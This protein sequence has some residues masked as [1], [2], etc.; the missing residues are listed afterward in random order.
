M[1]PDLKFCPI[2]DLVHQ[3]C[4]QKL[5]FLG[6]VDLGFLDLNNILEWTVLLMVMWSWPII[7]QL[8]DI[9]FCL[10][11]YISKILSKNLCN[12]NVSFLVS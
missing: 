2:L 10:H 6:I 1:S 12:L 7:Y 9:H 5:G 8:P 4:L 3:K 11:L